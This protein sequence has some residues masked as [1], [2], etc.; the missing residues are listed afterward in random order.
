MSRSFS[1]LF[2]LA[3][4]CLAAE[5]L[6]VLFIAV[7]DLRPELRCYG[8]T[9]IHSP[10]IDALAARGTLFERTYCQVAVCGASRASLMTGLRPQTTR[11]WNFRTPMREMNP[12]AL[13]MPQHFKGHGYE[14]ISIGK[15]YHAYIDDF[16]QGWS[17]KPQR[18]LGPQYASPAGVAAHRNANRIQ[19]STG[20]R[21][22]GP[23]SENG[24]EVSDDA[25]NDGIVAKTAVARLEKLAAADKPF[26]LAVGFS[27]PHLPFNAPG[28]YWDLYERSKIK[29]PS[30]DKVIEGLRYDGSS[31][32]ELKNYSDIS[33]K[34]K[35][36]NDAQTR[37]LIHGYRASVSYMDA[38]VGRLIN[39]L[40]TTGLVQNT[41]IVLWGDHG[42][43]LGDYGEWCKH[44]TYEIAAKVPLIVAA[45]TIKGGQVTKAL[46]ELVDLFPTLCDLSGIPIPTGLHG[47]S[48][49]PLLNHPTLSWREAAF[50]QYFKNKPGAG[51]V[52][53]TS[54]RTD[55]YRYTEW[56]QK[57]QN[58]PLEDV[59]LIDLQKDPGATKNIA[60]DPTHKQLLKR[61]GKLAGQSGRGLKPSDQK[62]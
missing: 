62:K 3:S 6:N 55:R 28:K 42:Y 4:P 60:A 26:F 25:Y 45:P 47:V 34:T 22:N 16:P 27:K 48:L 24:G 44:T 17:Q 5:K 46:T 23:A 20:V 38:Q 43:S 29:V 19:K 35:V 36:L 21:S 11:C 12:E 32:G 14:T 31:W 37:E 2:L 18:G 8:N 41:I 58:G 54:I 30:R 53:G 57:D 61:L 56:R 59:T 33:K 9:D 50:S 7:D 1:L 10:N 15:I 52:L 40:E 39:T 49:K 13:S 51:R